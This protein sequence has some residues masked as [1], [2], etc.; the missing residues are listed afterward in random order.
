MIQTLAALAA[1]TLSAASPTPAA[2]LAQPT[3]S[4]PAEAQPTAADLVLPGATAAPD[5]GPRPELSNIAFC[6]TA[7]LSAIGGLGDA[8]FARFQALGWLAADGDDNRV[9]FI[10]RREAGG[11]DGLQMLAFYDQDKPTTG[12]EPGY[13][14][15]AAVPGDV[16]AS[17]PSATPPASEPQ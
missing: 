2:A 4:P 8:Y 1:L 16:C 17:A 5:C 15:F 3:Q 11:C 6:V 14:A 12:T 10:R 9:I 13:L 7:P